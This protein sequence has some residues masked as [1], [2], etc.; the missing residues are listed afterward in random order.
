LTSPL[1]QSSCS[2]KCRKWAEQ[3]TALAVLGH[4]YVNGTGQSRKDKDVRVGFGVGPARRQIG[5]LVAGRSSC[6]K[7]RSPGSQVANRSGGRTQL[8]LL[9][10]AGKGAG[11]PLDC[12]FIDGLRWDAHH[13]NVHLS[14]L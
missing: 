1:Q 8:L 6:H 9:Q 5:E 14:G 3:F 10:F 13:E 11:D 7:L 2:E 12:R 4:E